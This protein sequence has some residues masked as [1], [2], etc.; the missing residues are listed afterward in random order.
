MLDQIW[1]LPRTT[2]NEG[3]R[4]DRNICTME[5]V[6]KNCAH[7]KGEEGEIIEIGYLSQR[8][9]DMKILN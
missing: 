5:L 6:N 1:S 3:K 8:L 2:N 9:Q 7:G 4:Q